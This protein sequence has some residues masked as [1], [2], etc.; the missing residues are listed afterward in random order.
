MISSGVMEEP[1]VGGSRR[2]FARGRRPLPACLVLLG[3]AAG[4][5]KA[6]GPASPPPVPVEA[7]TLAEHPVEQATEF[8]GTVKS[9]RSTT[10]QPQVEGFL[11]KILVRSGDRVQPGT[12]LMQ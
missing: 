12:P 9:R 3:L 4:C 2:R 10:V 8:V 1:E 7:I 6:A 11:T 5:G